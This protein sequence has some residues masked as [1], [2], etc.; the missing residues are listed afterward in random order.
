MIRNSFHDNY[1]TIHCD[2]RP[3]MRLTLSLMTVVNLM[4]VQESGCIFD[5]F[6]CKK[7]ENRKDIIKVIM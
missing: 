6:Y 3:E 5:Q 2:G 4:T 1:L 7:G